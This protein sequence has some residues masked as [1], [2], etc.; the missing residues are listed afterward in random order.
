MTEN[1]IRILIA[2]DS[3]V[4]ALLLRAIFERE[5]DFQI[6]GRARDGREAVRLNAE[7]KP[8]LVT[9]D[10]RM[11]E[12]DGFEATR[13]IMA[14]RPAPI[15]VISSSVDDEELKTT[16]RA[17]EEGALAVLEKP[18]GFNHPQFESARRQIVETVRAM[19]EVKVIRRA[20]PAPSAEINLFETAIVQHAQAQELVAI[21]CSTGGPAALQIVLSTLPLKFPIPIVIVQHISKGFL[22]GLI[23]WLAGNTL[24]KVRVAA[25]GEPF[26]PGTVYFA[27]DDRHLLVARRDGVLIARLDDGPPANG[28]RPSATPLMKSVAATCKG[29]AIGAILTG[30]G[31]D[32][33]EGLLA[34]KNA[35]AATLV[36]D[37][38][39]SVV[40]GM[41]GA[42]LAL[43]AADQ[44]VQLDKMTAYLL[45]LARR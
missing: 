11:P 29:R 16:F 33:A 39:S 13:L 22:G 44:V 34:M 6:V 30:M 1:K 37:E 27:P 32:G 5:P 36:Q 4:V 8:D 40:F 35:G 26:L 45:A 15:V 7:L 25:E 28:F 10:I 23:T 42:A 31:V 14:T 18:H 12:M 21:G 19:A 3:D 17:I 9:M 20:R 41:P 38:Q 24:L 43:G 2:E